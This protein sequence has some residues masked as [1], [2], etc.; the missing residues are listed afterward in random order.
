MR[1]KHDGKWAR[2]IIALQKADGT[3]GRYFHTLSQP[4]AENP[5][6]TEQ[7]LRRLRVLGFTIEDEPIRRAVDCMAACLRGERLIDDYNEKKHDWPLFTKLMLSTWVKL[8]DPS[9]ELAMA[10][11]RQWAQ[12][13]EQSFETGRFDKDAHAEA[14]AEIFGRRPSAQSGFEIGYGFLYDAYLLQRV[15]SPETERRLLDFYLSKPDG[16]YYVGSGRLTEL[17]P[18]F[19]SRRASF[20]IAGLEILAEYSTAGEKLGFA[21]DWLNAQKDTDGQWDMGPKA[22]DGIYFPLSDSWR[23]PADRK[24]DCTER[25]K[26][27]LQKIEN[28]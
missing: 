18:V 20:Y 26:N 13:A 19:A 25:V 1:A 8:F 14:F 3:W 28:K 15:L 16:I 17:P 5:M 27:L 9:N 4:T 2:Q 22:N 6:T 21:A 11:A 7:A 12:V 23:K 24:A 10:F